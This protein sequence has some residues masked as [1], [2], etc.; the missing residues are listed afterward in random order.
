MGKFNKIETSIE[1]LYI[2]EPTVF[3]DGRG[4]FFESYSKRDFEQLGISSEFVQ[5]NHSK[6]SKG[7]LRGLHFQTQQ[8]QG[9]LIRVIS[10]S[11]LDVS[12]DLRPNSPTYGKSFSVELTSENRRMLYVP[13][14]FAHGFLTLEDNTEFLYKCTNYYHPESDCGIIWNDKTIAIDWQFDRF[15][16]D[17]ESL[18]ISEKDSKLKSFNQLDPTQLWK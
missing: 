14:Q 15:S 12:V 16:I 2:I 18:I 9:K 17:E 6:S 10:G 4:C 11:V 3:G 8:I 7:V 5:D 1:G 13:E